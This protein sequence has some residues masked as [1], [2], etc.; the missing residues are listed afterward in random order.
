MKIAG[1]KLSEH[2]RMT[3][4][5]RQVRRR[6]V[7]Y[8]IQEEANLAEKMY[9]HRKLAPHKGIVAPRGRISECIQRRAIIRSPLLLRFA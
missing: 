5:R 8:L 7:E 4:R 9:T 2:R 6:G 3:A 1:E